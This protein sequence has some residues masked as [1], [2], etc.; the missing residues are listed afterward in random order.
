MPW[1]TFAP[2]LYCA[3]PSCWAGDTVESWCGCTSDTFCSEVMLPLPIALERN[4]AIHSHAISPSSPCGS[5]SANQIGFAASEETISSCTRTDV[6]YCYG[7]L[8]PADSMKPNRLRTA[9]IARLRR[10]LHPYLFS[11]ST[12]VATESEKSGPLLLCAAGHST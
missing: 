9:R 7:S 11:P 5:R 10:S 3:S 8:R 2:P 1:G 12:L 6:F 4:L